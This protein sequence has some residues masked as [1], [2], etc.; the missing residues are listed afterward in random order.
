MAMKIDVEDSKKNRR[1]ACIS[2]K[3]GSLLND[4]KDNDNINQSTTK[5]EA[6]SEK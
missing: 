6:V 1:E 4:G 2:E 5:D 3:G